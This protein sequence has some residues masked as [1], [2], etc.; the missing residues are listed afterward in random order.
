MK[1]Q[2]PVQGSTVTITKTTPLR[3]KQLQLRQQGAAVGSPQTLA[4]R[5]GRLVRY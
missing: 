2:H 3:G 1:Q 5:T 4:R